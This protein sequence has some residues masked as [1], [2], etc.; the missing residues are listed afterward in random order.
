MNV[1]QLKNLTVKNK[2]KIILKKINLYAKTGDI[3]AIIGANGVGKSSLLKAIMKHFSYKI[4]NGSLSYNN[5]KI[6]NFS[7]YDMAKLGFYYLD[8]NPIGI[9]G[10]KLIDLYRTI[11]QNCHQ[12]IEM[13]DF[14][15][16]IMLELK[17]FNLKP[18]ILNLDNTMLSG[19]QSKKNELIQLD[20][21]DPHVIMLDEID[22]GCDVDFIKIIAK[23]V[24]KIKVNKIIFLV[25]HQQK[26][27]NLIKP[28]KFILL[29]N[30]MIAET[31]KNEKIN[32][33]LNLG[34]EKYL[35]NNDDH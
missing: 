26:L 20:L 8:Q 14:Y 30:N 7:T 24:N 2:K 9:E 19:G 18:D 32:K 15:K 27:F 6:N 33:I 11:Y 10:I 31:G 25:S 23:Y 1:L 28:N 4:T 17:Q 22:S 35:K 13:V 12:K 16:K 34:F 3:I 5:K 21:I 29:H